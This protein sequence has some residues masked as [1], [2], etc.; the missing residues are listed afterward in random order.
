MT[1]SVYPGKHENNSIVRFPFMPLFMSVPFEFP[2]SSR[3]P[4]IRSIYMILDF[5][6]RFLRAMSSSIYTLNEH[7]HGP[8][9]TEDQ[10]IWKFNRR[11]ISNAKGYL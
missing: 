9:G 8:A 4:L 2:D 7:K 11:E 10:Y 1:Y 5:I 6:T 3:F